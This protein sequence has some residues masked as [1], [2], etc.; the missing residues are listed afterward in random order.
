MEI[1]WG[2]EPH[3]HLA[4]ERI[5]QALSWRSRG[6]RGNGIPFCYTFNTWQFSEI[7]EF[8]RLSSL[9]VTRPSALDRPPPPGHRLSSRVQ[10][11]PVESLSYLD[12]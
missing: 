9:C 2:A 7:R 1:A 12:P 6:I 4:W 8:R 10:T 5:A 3:P 11:L